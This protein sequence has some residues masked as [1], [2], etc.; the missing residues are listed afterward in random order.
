MPKGG[1]FLDL[2]SLL[3]ILNLK[4]FWPQALL[5][6]AASSSRP[7]CLG[8]LW[9]A[10]SPFC[11]FPLTPPPVSRIPAAAFGIIDCSVSGPPKFCCQGAASDTGCRVP[12]LSGS[13][14]VEPWE[15]P[16]LW[17]LAVQLC[18]VR[19]G[20]REQT[21]QLECRMAGGCDWSTP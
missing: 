20:T 19:W 1:Q 2:S 21:V 12:T 9:E 7:V 8:L 13:F 6:G 4:H 5:P 14:C 15:S 11:S 16:S 18:R 10:K 17:G 3:M